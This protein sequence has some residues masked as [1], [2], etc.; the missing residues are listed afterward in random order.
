[1]TNDWI[2]WDGGECPFKSNKTVVEIKLRNGVTGMP[3]AKNARWS[4][5][6]FVSDIIAYRIVEDHE[7]KA[8]R[9]QLTA[10]I[11]ALQKQL[12]AMPKVTRMYYNGHSAWTA[13]FPADTRYSKIEIIS[14]GATH[15]FNV[16]TIDGAPHIN[17]VAMKEVMK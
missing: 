8:T 7:P 17:G 16:E 6:G 15:Y 13:E 10:Q 14:S 1:M 2:K 9:E 12:S 5:K 4:A 3:F 11:A